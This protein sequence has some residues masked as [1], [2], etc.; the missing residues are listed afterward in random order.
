[1]AHDHD[2]AEPVVVDPNATHEVRD[3]RVRPIIGFLIALGI[4]T[5]IFCLLMALLF[6]YFEK[7]ELKAEGT[8]PPMA[9]GR[10]KIPPEPRLQLAPTEQG[11]KAPD[12]RDNSPILEMKRLREAQ[13]AKRDN[14]T[15]LDQQKGIVSIPID[16]A[17]RLAL[18]RGMFQAR[19][20]E[21]VEAPK[22]TAGEEAKPAE[23]K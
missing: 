14:Y 18:Q 22:P 2:T 1:M 10:E 12:L 16:Q 17:K 23:P 5:A 8:P 20:P 4:F 9:A 13:E 6:K 21:K 15:W 11:Q 3:V 7:Q 19:A